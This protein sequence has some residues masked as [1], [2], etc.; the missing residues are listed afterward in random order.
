MSFPFISDKA[1][2]LL[3][4]G[5]P[6]RKQLLKQMGLPYQSVAS[7]INENE[8]KEAPEATVQFLAE[9]KAVYVASQTGG[10]WTV[11]ADTVVVID[12]KVLG[13]PKDVEDARRMLSVL[14]GRT[15]SV[16][17]GI[18]II[19]PAGETVCREF[20]TTQVQ[21]IRL[22]RGQIDGY[23]KTGEPYG[24]AGGYAIQGIGA[25]LVE[26]ISGSYSNVVGLPVGRLINVL[27]TLGA[28]KEFPY[29]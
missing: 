2:L 1:P 20:V 6:R 4:S 18:C 12:K 22:G 29:T 11:G 14:N 15:H 10:L 28:L 21:F 27:L 9:K 13:K 7:H 24:K 3:A 17:T 19:N 5:S 8:I 26:R 16:I 25:F 23:I